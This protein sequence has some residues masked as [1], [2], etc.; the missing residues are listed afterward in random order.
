M[1]QAIFYNDFRFREY[2]FQTSRYSDNRMGSPMHF[3]AVLEAGSC[4]IVSP[5]RT[6]TLQAGDAFYIPMGLPYQS[7][8]EGPRIHFLSYG[9]S[10]FPDAADRRFQLQLLPKAAQMIRR[11]PITP[12]PNAQVLGHFYQV[13]GNLVPQ[14]QTDPICQTKRLVEQATDYIKKNPAARI[15]QV[16]THCCVSE[17]YLYT[18]FQ[19]ELNITPN[20]T[21]Q[22]ALMASA[23]HLLTTTDL[24]VTA[25]S[26][27]LGF[28]DISYFRKLLKKSTGKS[29]LQIRKQGQQV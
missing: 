1:K 26:D 28:S 2:R 7:Y 10:L 19:K 14:M 4:R 18:A 6:I 3:L 27:S 24:S 12:T 25:I 5:G 9:F 29:P 11:I 15:G 16:A 17:S 23:V 13:L 20:Q 21:R 8:W 22:Q